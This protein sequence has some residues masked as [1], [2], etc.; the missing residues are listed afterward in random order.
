VPVGTRKYRKLIE[1]NAV[2]FVIGPLH[3]GIGLATLPLIREL[4][5]VTFLQGEALGIT[6]AE[7]NRY[8]FRLRPNTAIAA[9][10]GA[11]LGVERL[12]KKWTFVISDF[13][14]GHATFDDFK[15]LV[16]K[17]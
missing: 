4:K 8:V 2:D 3:S 13:A 15:P 9:H 12:G 7:S 6:G 5:T 16:E 1:E 10:A 14:W 11:A 17:A